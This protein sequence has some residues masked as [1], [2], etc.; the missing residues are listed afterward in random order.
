MNFEK[1]TDDKTAA[2]VLATQIYFEDLKQVAA[3]LA[4]LLVLDAAGSPPDHPM[5]SSARGAYQRA[6]DGLRSIRVPMRARP[7][8]RHLLSAAVYL[9]EALHGRGDALRPLE[10]AWADLRAAS[11]TLP[12]FPIISFD[13]GCCAHS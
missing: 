7:H 3:Q 6:I 11:R 12:G 13:R 5:L 9:N 2:Y 8:H 4:G 10:S 1:T